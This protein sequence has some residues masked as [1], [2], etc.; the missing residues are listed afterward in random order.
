MKKCLVAIAA[1]A[2][3]IFGVLPLC[4]AQSLVGSGQANVGGDGFHVYGVTG[5]AG[6][7]S[8]N[9]NALSLR[10]TAG[11]GGEVYTWAAVALGFAHQKGNHT[12]HINYTPAYS[13]TFQAAN[14]HSFNQNIN[15]EVTEHVRPQWTMYLRGSADDSTLQQFLFRPSSS[16]QLVSDGNADQLASTVI[17]APGELPA[18]TTPLQTTFYGLRVLS[19]GSETGITYKA[20]PRLSISAGGGFAQ[21]QSRPDDQNAPSRVLLPRTRLE[22]GSVNVAYSLSPRSAI[23]ANA[24]T[25]STQSGFGNS[26]I[27]IFTGNYG[28]KLGMH[29]FGNVAGGIGTFH[30]SKTIGSIPSGTSYVASGTLGYQTQSQAWVASYGRTVGDTYGLVSGSTRTFLGAWNY[31]RPGMVWGI[32]TSGGQQELKGGPIGTFTT[33]HASAGLI[34]AVSSQVNLSMEYAYI[35]DTT[36]PRNQYEDLH[37]HI[38]RLTISWIPLLGEIG[39]AAKRGR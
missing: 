3:T 14:L 4:E 34:R 13:G 10:D 12:F 37:A 33:W 25:I 18:V 22:Q 19:F 5:S 29:W 36:R 28:R 8:L 17:G 32:V 9:L 24:S 23:G 7:S 2:F 20:S 16:S 26:Q 21:S 27:S 35:K 30:T 11:M 31:K 1:F 6:Y 38:V 15:F 39:A